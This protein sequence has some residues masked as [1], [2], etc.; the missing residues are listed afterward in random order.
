MS[1]SKVFY[2]LIQDK[3]TIFQSVEFQPN[4]VIFKARLKKEA[5]RCPCCQSRD[6]RIK[7]TKERTFRM[8]NLGED[9]TL[10]TQ[11]LLK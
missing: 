5:K 8:V 4:E 2:T 10:R 9:L 1:I 6:V 11:P 7:E 3:N